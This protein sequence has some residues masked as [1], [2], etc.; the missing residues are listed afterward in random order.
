MPGPKL[1]YTDSKLGGVADQHAA[2]PWPSASATGVGSMPGTDVAEALRLVL[3]ELPDLPH[4]PELPGRGPGADL[5][6]R[7]AG[8]LVDLPVETTPSGWRFAS[9]PG[10]D[11]RR[12]RGYMARD[13]DALAE[14]AVGYAGPFKIQLC[15]PWTLAATIGLG[16]DQNPALADA[17]AVR[18]LAASLAEGAASHA[19]EVARRLPGARL[20]LQLDE[21]A[22]A[23]VVAGTVPTASGLGRLSAVDGHAMQETIRAVLDAVPESFGIIHCCAPIGGYVG[24]GGPSPRA[25]GLPLPLLRGAGARAVSF[26][27][28]L[29]RPGDE[30]AIGEAVDSGQGLLAGVLPALPAGPGD[31]IAVPE[32]TARVTG[33]WRRLGLPPQ[34][35]AER[36]VLTPAC[37]LAGAPESY[38][39]TALA[40]CRD[41]A[42]AV[43]EELE[44]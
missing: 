14:I 17:I 8:L 16:A 39:R 6:G 2:F 15:G 26:D 41:A 32:V 34:W 31:A 20:L 35:C 38:A 23:A 40:S 28:S 36:V 1:T 24:Y 9:R 4:L 11:L 29:L 30:D 25:A 3:G 21:P 5:T 19:A 13:L 33:L 22:L 44:G 37:G 12:A 43:R 18:D 10:R 42:R 27:L 7:T